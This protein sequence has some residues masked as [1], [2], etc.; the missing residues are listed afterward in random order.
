MYLLSMRAGGNWLTLPFKV[1]SISELATLGEER[2]IK[3]EEEQ[4]RKLRK[5]EAAGKKEEGGSWR[6]GTEGWEEG[7]GGDDV[8]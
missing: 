4:R 7:E 6:S 1:V 2:R 5:L 8:E 3:R